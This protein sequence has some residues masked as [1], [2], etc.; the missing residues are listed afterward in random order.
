MSVRLVTGASRWRLIRQ[1]LIEGMMLAAIGGGFGLASAVWLSRAI[2]FIMSRD[3]RHVLPIDLRPDA[4]ILLFTLIVSVAVGLLFGLA[5]ALRATRIR[6]LATTLKEN[7][8]TTSARLGL[9]RLLIGLQIVF[10]LILLMGAGLFVHTL[11]NLE[12]QNF[13]FNWHNVLLFALDPRGTQYTPQTINAIYQRALEQ[14]QH[15]PGVVSATTSQVALLSGW[16][17]NGSISPDVT[18]ITPGQPTSVYWNGVGP[19][20]FQTMDISLLLG[21]PIDW[22]DVQGSRKVGVVNENLAQYFF[23]GENPIGHSFNFGS[24]R[25]PKNDFVIIGV[26]RNA[27]YSD[28]RDQAPRTLYVPYTAAPEPIGRMY[29]EV[30][31]SGEPWKYLPAIRQIVFTI[32]PTLPLGDIKTQ[33]EQIEENLGRERM[34]AWAL[35]CFGVL[36]LILVC[37][38]LYGTLS[39]T[40]KRRTRE[41]GIRMALG[42]T[43]AQVLWTVLRESLSLAVIGVAVGVPVALA[44][45]RIIAGQLFRVKPNDFATLAGSILILLTVAALAGY[46]PARNAAR[47]DPLST[48]RYE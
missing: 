36:A 32:D 13:G 5:P 3:Q 12:N 15:T 4:R 41:I 45:T 34:F 14:I 29:F 25:N 2:L 35:S 10:S 24:T 1:V 18:Q 27:K 7:A 30:R 38:G 11:Q 28:V 42:A 46:L 16:I 23:P 40:V 37:V 8:T 48:L 39:Y 43:P 9:A 20:F 6:D 33:G 47:L 21:R 44:L 31:T 17:N 26:V 22:R 19:S